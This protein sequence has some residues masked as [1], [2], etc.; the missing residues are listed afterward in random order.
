M[1][2]IVQIRAILDDG[3]DRRVE[4]DRKCDIDKLFL[5]RVLHARNLQYSW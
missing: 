3:E 4:S 5:Y 1:Q 2:P